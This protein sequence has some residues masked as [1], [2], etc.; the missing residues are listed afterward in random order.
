MILKK[1]ISIG[2]ESTVR[3]SYVFHKKC[4]STFNLKISP[5]KTIILSCQKSV[6]SFIID[7]KSKH[8]DPP[9][10]FFIKIQNRVNSFYESFKYF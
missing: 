6:S 9:H 7:K 1:L 8:D 2:N 3:I 4:K 5:R 10:F